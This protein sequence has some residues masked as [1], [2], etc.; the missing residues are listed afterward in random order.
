MEEPLT[1]IRNCGGLRYVHS[2]FRIHNHFARYSTNPPVA[3]RT[4][5][6]SL[7]EVTYCRCRQ[8]WMSLHSAQRQDTLLSVF[9]SKWIILRPDGPQT[10]VNGWHVERDQKNK[11]RMVVFLSQCWQWW[12]VIVQNVGQMHVHRAVECWKLNKTD[13]KERQE[14]NTH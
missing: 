4:V 14:N 6:R 5:T 7:V 12:S 1:P 10:I 13:L 8:V 3:S 2:M 11:M 9:D